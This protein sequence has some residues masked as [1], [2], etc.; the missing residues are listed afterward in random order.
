MK[1]ITYI[2]GTLIAFIFYGVSNGFLLKSIATENSLEAFI[3]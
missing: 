3:K 1:I 2:V